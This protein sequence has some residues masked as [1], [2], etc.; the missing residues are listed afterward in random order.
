VHYNDLKADLAGEMGRV[1]EFLGIA[2]PEP[3]W[4][5]VVERCTFESMQGRGPQIGHFERF[6]EGGAKGFLFKGTNGRWRDVLTPDELASYASR[7]AEVLPTA[8]GMWL[9]GGRHAADPRES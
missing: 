4:P 3:K 7:V 2:I 9:E 8:A 1:A 5:A 6:F